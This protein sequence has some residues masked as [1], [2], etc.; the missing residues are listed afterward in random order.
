MAILGNL[1]NRA[2]SVI[3]TQEYTYHKFSN[4]TTNEY[5]IDEVTYL[6][7]T[8]YSGSLQPVP[9]SKY[10]YMGLD[11]QKRYFML[12]TTNEIL[13]IDRDVSGDQFDFAGK[14][15]QCISIESN[16]HDVDGWCGVLS[17]EIE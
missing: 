6:S 2:F 9:R 16:W 5:G 17:V 10:E 14:R 1:L 12:Y 13:D 15:Y 3:P 8:N 4:R 11:Y 7:A